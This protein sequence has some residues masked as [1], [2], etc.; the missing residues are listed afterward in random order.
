M[1]SK[2]WTEKNHKELTE[3][4]QQWRARQTEAYNTVLKLEGALEA[5]ALVYK[6]Q[7]NEQDNQPAGEAA[8]E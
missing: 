7:T 1:I 4:L 3:Q 6:E 5:L 2:E 8:A